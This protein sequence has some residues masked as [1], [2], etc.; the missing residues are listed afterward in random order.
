LGIGVPAFRMLWS[1]HSLLKR[2]DPIMAGERSMSIGRCGAGEFQPVCLRGLSESQ[3]NLP[4]F[5][6]VRPGP[7]VR[8]A[9]PGFQP[10]HAFRPV[11]PVLSFAPATRRPVAR[12][13]HSQARIRT[14]AATYAV[15]ARAHLAANPSRPSPRH[16]TAH[17]CHPSHVGF[18]LRTALAGRR[19]PGT[20]NL[21][22]HARLM[23]LALQAGNA[24][25][26][27]MREGRKRVNA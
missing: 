13:S 19:N 14:D 4:R 23:E 10:E 2:L 5:R 20:R 18:L 7:P 17:A 24:A 15:V 22:F 6:P 21:A 9:I 26:P 16:A 1:T 25:A 12:D 27:R 8:D 11:R 3:C